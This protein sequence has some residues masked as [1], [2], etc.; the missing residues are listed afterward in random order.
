[1]RRT[2][3]LPLTL[4]LLLGCAPTTTGD[5]AEQSRALR[6]LTKAL[7]GLEDERARLAAHEADEP[8]VAG[9]VAELRLV[10]HQAE[11]TAA[12]LPEG[13]PDGTVGRLEA[14]GARMERL[15]GTAGS[16]SDSDRPAALR[17]AA[18][19]L[20]AEAQGLSAW[21][22]SEVARVRSALRRPTPDAGWFTGTVPSRSRILAVRIAAG[23]YTAATFVGLVIA[24]TAQDML[25]RR[26]RVLNGVV[27]VGLC[28]CGL[29]AATVQAP[30]VAGLISPELVIPD[31]EQ[32]CEAAFQRG[33]ELDRALR[34]AVERE[35]R[36]QEQWEE[37]QAEGVKGEGTAGEGA[38][39]E[40]GSLSRRELLLR[41]RGGSERR[42]LEQPAPAP[43][44]VDPPPPTG[45]P[46]PPSGPARQVGADMLARDVRAL[47]AECA[48][49]A[50]TPAAVEEARYH[51]A[52]ASEYLGQPLAPAPD[53]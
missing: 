45:A 8:A 27:F 26:R 47:A 32:V 4:V 6:L 30:L 49:F 28:A 46:A 42:L 31:G 15:R 7:A 21:L 3:S 10:L 51:H 38:A 36:K 11:R 18:G 43:A 22:R 2:A 20:T 24:L 19:E 48:A 16:G 37:M 12:R 13:L 9:A 41:V 1:M 33:A 34:I 52:L 29:L 23:I 44:P 40:V 17:A 25:A 39:G 14:L 53:G 5:H 50:V 35:A